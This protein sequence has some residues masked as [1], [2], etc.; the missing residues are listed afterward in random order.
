MK[1]GDEGWEASCLGLW[2]CGLAPGLV[3]FNLYKCPDAF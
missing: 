1:G 3:C 2:L